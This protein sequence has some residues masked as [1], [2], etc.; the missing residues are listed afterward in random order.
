M[1]TDTK[2][3]SDH[4]LSLEIIHLFSTVITSVSRGDLNAWTG[5]QQHCVLHRWTFTKTK[6]DWPYHIPHSQRKGRI[7]RHLQPE[8]CFEF[9]H[10]YIFCMKARNASGIIYDFWPKIVWLRVSTH[11][12]SLICNWKFKY[13]RTMRWHVVASIAYFERELGTHMQTWY[14]GVGTRHEHVYTPCG[15]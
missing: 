15:N 2:S 10:Q 3:I 12:W 11:Y 4:V 6:Y 1:M 5:I 8:N 7:S 14:Q 13:T 9:L